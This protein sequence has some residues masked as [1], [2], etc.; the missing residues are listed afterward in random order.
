MFFVIA[1]LLTWGCSQKSTPPDEIVVGISSE[2][3]TLDPRFATDAYGMRISHL[4]FNALVQVGPNLEVA[5]DAARSWTFKN[6]V[7]TFELYPGLRFQNGRSLTPEDLIFS[8]EQ[9][10]AHNSPFASSFD[11]VE[12][13]EARE[14][15]DHLEVTIK[16][17]QF[18]AGFLGGD[19]PVLKILPK[20]EIAEFPAKLIGTGS[21][22]LLSKTD[23]DIELA[24]VK[25]HAIESPKIARVDFKV[26]HDDFTRF[27]KMIKGEL[28]VVFNDLSNDKIHRF[29]ERPKEFRV[30]RVPSASMSYLLVNMHDP[31]LSKREVREAVSQAIHRSEIIRYKLNGMAKE[32]T[33]ILPLM[34]PYFNSEL[35]NPDYDPAQAKRTIERLGL[36][37]RSLALKCSNN[38]DVADRSKVI[39]YELSKIGLNVDLETYEWGKFYEDVKKGNFQLASMKWVGISDP[40]IYRSAFNSREKPPGGRNRGNYSNSTVDELTEK[41]LTLEPDQERKAAY[42]KIQKI[43]LE[44]YAFIPLWTDL[45]V[46]VMKKNIDGFEP[47]V[48]GDY[49]ILTRM[50]KRNA[51]DS[52]VS[53]AVTTN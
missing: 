20:K 25:D 44:D 13:F 53:A 12:K 14:N 21:F 38:P 10:R 43:V 39:A 33:S 27:Q 18:V 29:E 3:V 6:N 30:Y 1:A 19:L 8:Y 9:F 48:P 5:P 40:D 17:K 28:D 51:L 7:Y 52:H 45:Q 47:S 32:T 11:R 46:T 22:R 34:H 50:E 36:T 23:A 49:Q 2:P 37:G 26:V 31:L 42:L 4:I 15:G 16:M 24:A 35:R 41:A